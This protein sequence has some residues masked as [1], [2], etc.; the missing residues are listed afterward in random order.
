MPLDSG[1]RPRPHNAALLREVRAQRDL[2]GF[3]SAGATLKLL[4][5]GI[6]AKP[7]LSLEF[8]GG[9][10]SSRRSQGC[11][12]P[13]RDAPVPDADPVA[14][15][16]ARA[17]TSTQPQAEAGQVVVVEDLLAFVGW[18]RQSGDRLVGEP[19]L[20]FFALGRLWDDAVCFLVLRRATYRLMVRT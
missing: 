1:V 20:F 5:S 15:D 12:R 14:V 16:P 3:G 9:S 11:R 4:A 2:H 18:Q 10:S 19:H 8:S 7:H 13:E 6:G 17:A